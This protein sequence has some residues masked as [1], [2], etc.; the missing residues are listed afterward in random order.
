MEV[1]FISPD[2]KS[3]DS[4]LGEVIVLGLFED[5]RPPQGTLGV[6]DYRM[7]GHVSSLIER[8]QVSGELLAAQVMPGRPKTTFERVVLIGAGPSERFEPQIFARVIDRMLSAIVELGMRR[9]VAELPGRPQGLIEPE[10]AYDILLDRA[11]ER[12]E[13]DTLTLLEPPAAARQMGAN[14]ATAADAARRS[15]W[16]LG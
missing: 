1:R 13:I 9:A 16:R 2:L 11:R 3:L 10:L 5:E 7:A 15:G 12:V 4:I 8:G 14:R 6:L